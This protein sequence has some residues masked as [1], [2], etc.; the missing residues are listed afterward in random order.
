MIEG[1]GDIGGQG[2]ACPA[3]IAGDGGRHGSG[4]GGSGL[5]EPLDFGLQGLGA[6]AALGFGGLGGGQLALQGVDFVGT[7][8]AD[9]ALRD[10]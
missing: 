9:S 4:L 10:G 6:G 8:S 3:W 5:I 7:G 1:G 2:L